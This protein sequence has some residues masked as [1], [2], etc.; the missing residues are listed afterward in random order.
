MNIP[1]ITS[2][3]DELLSKEDAERAQAERRTAYMNKQID[4]LLSQGPDC[5]AEDIARNIDDIMRNGF[6]LERRV[7]VQCL[8]KVGTIS[9]YPDHNP[10]HF[11]VALRDVEFSLHLTTCEITVGHPISAKQL[12]AIKDWYFNHGGQQKVSSHRRC[13]L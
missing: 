13:C 9:V 4:Y 1:R 8:P 5:L 12:K 6:V 3:D 10:P 11:H 7:V 2:K